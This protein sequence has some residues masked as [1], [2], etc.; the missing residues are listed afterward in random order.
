MTHTCKE[1][2]RYYICCSPCVGPDTPWI[3][4]GLDLLFLS[5]LRGARTNNEAQLLQL[6]ACRLGLSC[7]SSNDLKQ[8]ILREAN[9]SLGVF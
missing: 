1:N 7:L 6:L 4:A 2:K 5:V 9:R 3:K 8:H